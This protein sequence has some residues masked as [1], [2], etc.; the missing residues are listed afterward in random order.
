MAS[1]VFWDL[2]FYFDSHCNHNLIVHFLPV[3]LFRAQCSQLYVWGS[4]TT[5]INMK[6]TVFSAFLPFP[7]HEHC[8]KTPSWKHETYWKQ[9]CEN[10]ACLLQTLFDLNIGCGGETHWSPK[11]FPYLTFFTFF[12]LRDI[13][14]VVW[15]RRLRHKM[16][17]PPTVERDFVPP[18]A[19][20]VLHYVS[21]PSLHESVHPCLFFIDSSTDTTLLTSDST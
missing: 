4:I 15:R 20:Q 17:S 5:T 21:V 18:V 8:L 19:F 2:S 7:R 3:I 6:S 13:S 16:W 10:V 9:Q 1:I 12:Y 14:Y 11:T